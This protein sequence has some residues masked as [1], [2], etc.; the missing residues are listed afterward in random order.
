[1][2]AERVGTGYASNEACGGL[3]VDHD[4]RDG[5][6]RHRH[7]S[8]RRRRRERREAEERERERDREA[9]EEILLDPQ[10]AAYQRARRVAEEKT[11]LASDV[12]P[13][14]LVAVPLLIFAFPIGLF[15][16][17]F[18]GV[19]PAKRAYR[20]FVEPEIRER[21]VANEVEKQVHATLT[22]ERRHLEAE[23]ARSMQQ[24]SANIAHEIRNPITAAKSLVQQMEEDPA[25]AS[26]VEYARVALEE[27]ER[28]ERSVSHLLRFARDEEMGFSELRL[29]DVIASARLLTCQ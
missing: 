20:L 19:K 4:G 27:L 11:K 5:A 21:F 13:L 3:A 22:H 24:L 23:H 8:R 29:A 28:V 9:R 6:E 18:W 12:F 16:L 1:M 15:V 26:N 17:I 14:L 10:L 2:Q 25:A 7:G